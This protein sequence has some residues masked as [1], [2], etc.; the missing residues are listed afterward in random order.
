[1][2]I[3]VLGQGCPRC[4]EVAKRTLNLLAELNIA[5]D[6]QKVTDLKAIAQYNIIA[7]PG[8]VI[9]GTVKCAGRIPSTQEI[10]KWLE[11]EIKT[12]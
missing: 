4:E 6:F 3:R 12:A 7:T 5:A 1:M 8:L 9:N 10:K 2:E 11:E